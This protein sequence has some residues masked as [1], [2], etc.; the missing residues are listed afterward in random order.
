MY[1]TLLEIDSYVLFYVCSLDS[2][3]PIREE[4]TQ[5]HV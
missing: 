3:F 4:N 5:V 2:I 1:Q